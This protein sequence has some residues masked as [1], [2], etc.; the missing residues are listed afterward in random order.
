MVVFTNRCGEENSRLRGPS[1]SLTPLML[2]SNLSLQERLRIITLYTDAKRTRTQIAAVTH[3]KLETVSYW[4]KRWEETGSVEDKPRPGAPPK[5]SIQDKAWMKSKALR[6]GWDA[7]K[8][9]TELKHQRRVSITARHVQRIL[10]ERGL[11][12]RAVRKKHPLTDADKEERLSWARKNKDRKWERVLF[13]D[14]FKIELGSRKRQRWV[15]KGEFPIEEKKAHPPKLNGWVAFGAA[16]P[17]KLTLFPENLTTDLHLSIVKEGVPVA[18]RKLFTGPWW[19][20][21]DNDPKTKKKKVFDFYA[22]QKIRRMPFPSYS[23]DANVAE[24]FIKELKDR[25]AKRG[26]RDLKQLEKFAQEE[27]K[28]MPKS[29][30]ANLVNSMPDRCQAIIDEEGGPTRY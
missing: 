4:I 19:L 7:S 2:H 9:S 18:T 20:L 6:L 15:K 27:F 17:G 25:T 30:C 29:L 13:T 12:S 23:P 1:L 22:S 16:G 14:Y 8:I 28:K 26:A 3:H 24:N 10:N 21:T 11:V 5:V